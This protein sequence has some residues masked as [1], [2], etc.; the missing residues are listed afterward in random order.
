MSD[1]GTGMF[2]EDMERIFKPFYT[3][4]KMGKSGTELGMAAV[5]GTVK[6][7]GGYIETT[8]RNIVIPFTC[9]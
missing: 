6:D 9:S 8:R 5:W 1:A 7:H 2:S 3:K 4:K